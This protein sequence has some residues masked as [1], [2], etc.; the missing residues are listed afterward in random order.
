LNDLAKIHYSGNA[1]FFLSRLCR[2]V[3][4]DFANC[5]QIARQV[6]IV[7]GLAEGPTSS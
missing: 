7:L 1:G 6:G 3:K 5:G 2:V 4:L